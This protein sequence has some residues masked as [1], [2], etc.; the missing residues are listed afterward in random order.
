MGFQDL[1]VVVIIIVVGFCFQ[2][3]VLKSQNMSCN[4]DDLASLQVF[5]T[6]LELGI[7]VWWTN[8]SSDC[9][10]W[11]G[12][13]CNS[14]SSLGLNDTTN[15]SSSDGVTRGLRLKFQ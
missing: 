7:D 2:A 11:V 8:S 1:W 12:I 9:C 5:S 15:D 14:S 3:Q 13:T 4:P 6:K 10:N